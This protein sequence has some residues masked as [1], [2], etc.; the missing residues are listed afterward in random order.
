MSVVVRGNR[1]PTRSDS[2][3]VVR[4]Q[5]TRARILTAARARILAAGFEA[6]RLDDIALDAGVTK[7][8]VVKSVGGKASI[9]LALGDEDRQTRLTI[10]REAIP[11]R[12]GLRRRLTEVTRR[13]LETAEDLEERGLPRAVGA[14]QAHP[15][16]LGQRERQTLK[17]G[18]HSVALG[19]RFCGKKRGGRTHIVGRAVLDTRGRMRTS[20]A[21]SARLRPLMRCS[22][23]R[24]LPHVRTR[25]VQTSR[26]GK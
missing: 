10:I 5:H 2:P 4:G 20:A 7:G 6:L 21:F 11:L 3:I 26:T 22:S 13:L 15:I 14:D 24:A 17:E 19:Q 25:R 9:L 12:S 8:G 18:L 1:K 23:E 16:S